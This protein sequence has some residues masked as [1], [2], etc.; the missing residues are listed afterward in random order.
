MRVGDRGRVVLPVGLRQRRN[1]TEGTTLVA[2]E[3]EQG[4]VLVGRDEL[5]KLLRD[6]LAGVSLVAGLLEERRQAAASEDAE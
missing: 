2:V 6:Q 1:W 3:T 4:V 5:E